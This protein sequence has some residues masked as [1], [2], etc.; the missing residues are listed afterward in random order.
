MTHP[1]RRMKLVPTMNTTPAR[2]VSEVS[3]KGR[4]HPRP[5]IQGHAPAASVHMSTCHS[6]VYFHVSFVCLFSL[7]NSWRGLDRG[8][9][10][11][12]MLQTVGR[13]GGERRLKHLLV[14]L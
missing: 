14:Y 9:D 11:G 3:C 13:L 2:Y 6:S 8:V 1:A 4:T 5:P 12:C 10:V 7:L